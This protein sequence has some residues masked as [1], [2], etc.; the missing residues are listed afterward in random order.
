MENNDVLDLKL[1]G[2]FV[3]LGMHL[4]SEIIHDSLF[5]LYCLEIS[6]QQLTCPTQLEQNTDTTAVGNPHLF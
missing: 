5:A 6:A 3:V 4:A 1:Q 2:S